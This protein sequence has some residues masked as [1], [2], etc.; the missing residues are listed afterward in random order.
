MLQNHLPDYFLAKLHLCL[1]GEQR[2]QAAF[3]ARREEEVG[4]ATQGQGCASASEYL[5]MC[6]VPSSLEEDESNQT[7]TKIPTILP[8]LTSDQGRNK[9]LSNSA[10]AFPKKTEPGNAGRL[11]SSSHQRT[12]VSFTE[13]YCHFIL[14]AMLLYQVVCRLS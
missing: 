12:T 7:A 11:R 6:T 5:S 8:S 9:A 13:V 3:V 2:E 4:H 14:K 10:L 1:L